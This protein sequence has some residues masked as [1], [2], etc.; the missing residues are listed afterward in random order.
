MTERLRSLYHAM[1]AF[2]QGQPKLIQHFTKVHSYAKLIGESEGLDAHA[3]E[4]LEAA[5][6]THD[7]AIPLCYQK[8][9]ADP[10]DLQ[11]LEGPPLARDMLSR[12]PFTEEEI[13][14]VCTLI[15]EHHTCD[16]IDGIDHQILLE[17][18][19][20]VNCFEHGDTKAQCQQVMD[21]MFA[22]AAGKKIFTLMFGLDQA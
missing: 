22:T 9:G 6:L 10:G 5:A 3:L 12:L 1:I 2:D 15:G 16:P 17:A 4:I 8:Y 7:I 14:R 18:D 13:S 20:L 11:E 19:F 21:R